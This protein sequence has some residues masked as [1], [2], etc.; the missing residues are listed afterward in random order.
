MNTNNTEKK[1]AISNVDVTWSK[2]NKTGTGRPSW[3]KHKPY[4]F[5][6]NTSQGEKI[7]IIKNATGP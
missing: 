3:S 6:G 5:R 4:Y 1:N 7:T 2:Y